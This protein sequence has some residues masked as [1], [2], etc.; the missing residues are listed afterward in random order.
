M[1][2]LLS[3][4]IVSSVI[5]ILL[6]YYTF[7]DT[8]LHF[9]R[10]LARNMLAYSAPL[11]FS[12]MGE[13]ILTY[14]DRYFLKA[15]G[16]LGEV[17]VYSLG[18][19]LGFV[20]WVFSV[21]P[22]FNIWEPQRFEIAQKE[23]ARGTNYRVFLLSNILIITLALIISL[24]SYDLFRIMSAPD[25]WAAYKVVPIIILAYIVQAWTSFGNFGLYYR[26][27]TKQIAL[28]TMGGAIAVIILSFLLIPTFKSYGAALA[29][30]LAFIIRFLLIYPRAQKYY[31]LSLPWKK[32]LM[33]LMAASLLYIVSQ[34]I[35]IDSILLSIAFQSI[36][37]LIFILLLF[38]LPIFG[39]REKKAVYE[40]IINPKTALK[41]FK[42]QS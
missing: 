23:D 1:G 17:G 40:I 7:H 42:G 26:G 6:L 33:L 9:S 37:V 34:Q 3:S 5:G 31:K 28:G 27:D 38:L 18:Y 35:S 10:A 32:C 11:I 4:L 29:T 14:S 30:L 21:K 25:F 19:K 20:L 2:V 12:Y 24:F 22:I 16:S 41:V 15:F 39:K 8:G 13:F 36:V